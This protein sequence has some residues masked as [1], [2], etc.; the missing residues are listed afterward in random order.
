VNELSKYSTPLNVVCVSIKSLN[1]L[2]GVVSIS[3]VFLDLFHS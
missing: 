2:V 1:I 3:L